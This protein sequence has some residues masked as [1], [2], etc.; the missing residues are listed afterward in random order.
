MRSTREVTR[1]L[2][3]GLGRLRWADGE[4]EIREHFPEARW[5]R[6]E[7]FYAMKRAFWLDAFDVS[8][9]FTTRAV[10]DPDNHGALMLCLIVG[11]D[12]W[13]DYS[14]LCREFG[15]ELPSPAQ[16]RQEER[17]WAHRGVS[18]IASPLSDYEAF[19]LWAERKRGA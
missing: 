10:I 8:P 14:A 3:L 5:G 19:G 11:E 17:A 1:D 7:P 9:G 4:E 18:L 2:A 12:R 6:V 16:L 15:Q 13:D